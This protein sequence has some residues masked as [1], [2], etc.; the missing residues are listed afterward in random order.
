MCQ[1]DRSSFGALLG[2]PGD[3]RE[4][5]QPTALHAAATAAVPAQRLLPT[6]Q[7]LAGPMQRPREVV[8]SQRERKDKFKEAV[9]FEIDFEIDF[10]NRL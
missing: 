5:S 1:T 2:V 8:I 10:V 7:V 6:V 4:G 3:Q 9:D